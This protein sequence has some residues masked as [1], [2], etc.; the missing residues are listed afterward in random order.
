MIN[1]ETFRNA[2]KL[3]HYTSIKNA[4]LILDSNQILFGKAMDMND[5]NE[6]KKQLNTPNLN[7]D[8]REVER[9][10][11]MFRQLSLTE[12]RPADP[13]SYNGF[14]ISAMWGHYADNGNGVCLVF[15]KKKLMDT[16]NGWEPYKWMASVRYV[17]THSYN[18][19]LQDM[20]RVEDIVEA[21]QEEL[22]FTKSMD[23][24]YEQEFRVVAKVKDD[25]ERLLCL[26]ETVLLELSLLMRRNILAIQ[27]RR[28][29]KI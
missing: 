28:S 13:N 5:I 18:K 26:W 27:S 20:E 15:D 14:S 9:E 11:K 22:F 29:S 16:I 10:L 1:K 3:Y 24:A 23:W 12:D 4:I 7:L 6:A 19:E 21:S 8:F 2:E 25:T 17:H